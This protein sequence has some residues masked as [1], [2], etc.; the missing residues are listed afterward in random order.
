[1]AIVLPKP[2]SGRPKHEAALGFEQESR[3]LRKNPWPQDECSVDAFRFLEKMPLDQVAILMAESNKSRPLEDSRVSEQ[4]A[5]DPHSPP[6]R[7]HGTGSA[8]YGPGA[9]V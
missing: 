9:E 4:V 3:T 7:G 2:D 1:M 6:D 8:W 5:A